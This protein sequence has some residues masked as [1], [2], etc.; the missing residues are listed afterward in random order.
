MADYYDKNPYEMDRNI[1][2][3]QRL[4]RGTP[5]LITSQDTDTSL[6]FLSFDTNVAPEDLATDNLN[7]R[8]RSA[9]R[10]VKTDI[11]RGEQQARRSPAFAELFEEELER[12]QPGMFET[13]VEPTFDLLQIGQF[14]FA[15]WAQEMF[16]S[17]NMG[18]AFDQAVIEFTNAL[19]GPVDP[20]AQRPGFADVLEEAGWDDEGTPG[21]WG[22]AGLGFILDVAF[23]PLT[24]VPLTTPLKLLG[25]TPKVGA[26]IRALSAVEDVIP[27]AGGF[28]EKFV[29]HFRLKQWGEKAG[30]VDEVD[31][32]L[33][34][35]REY[36]AA[37]T[38]GLQDMEE[39]WGS[40]L[41]GLST[42]EKRF[43]LRYMDQGDEVVEG[44][45]R[46]FLEDAGINK[47]SEEGEKVMRAVRQSRDIFDRYIKQETGEGLISDGAK[48]ANYVPKRAPTS[49]AEWR[50]WRDFADKEGLQEHMDVLT[51]AEGLTPY[52]PAQTLEGMAGPTYTH[53]STF[54][55]V[56]PLAF[57]HP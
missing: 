17:G 50:A 38:Q 54:K 19:P 56:L 30:K 52:L 12:D 26:S 35:K 14:T 27:A 10:G 22:R 18:K 21:R 7:M 13:L 8:Q 20:A 31:A 3:Q 6:P 11:R 48:V 57:L 1:L 25:L 4:Q 40:I 44:Q 9:Y 36:Q 47:A 33:D 16:R 41:N 39:V 49:K 5:G 32:W 23:D 42:E 55:T 53:S 37:E 2:R 29:P 43:M 15:G 51:Q 28:G 34:L 46:H 24:W 45:V